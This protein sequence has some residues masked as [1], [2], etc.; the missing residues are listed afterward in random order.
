MSIS[1]GL[2]SPASLLDCATKTAMHNGT[3]FSLVRLISLSTQ[4]HPF[5]YSLI[6]LFLFSPRSCCG[7]TTAGY[8]GSTHGPAVGPFSQLVLCSF[9]TEASSSRNLCKQKDVLNLRCFSRE[10]TQIS[11]CSVSTGNP[12]KMEKGNKFMFL[13]KSDPMLISVKHSQVTGYSLQVCMYMQEQ[14]LVYL[15]LPPKRI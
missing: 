4:I 2:L 7:G 11:C 14:K 13:Q 15:I 6:A 12:S 10:D 3:P 5:S 8:E 1:L 9:G